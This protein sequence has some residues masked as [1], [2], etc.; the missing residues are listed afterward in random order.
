MAETV[1]CAACGA[2]IKG[3]R[4]RCLRCGEALD[5]SVAPAPSRGRLDFVVGHRGPFAIGGAAF[6]LLAMV[7]LVAP[8]VEERPTVSAASVMPS[9]SS[10]ASVSTTPG[11][12]QRAPVLLEPRTGL[13]IQRLAN[14]AYMR[15]DFAGAL[16]SYQETVELNP[17]D[18]T[19]LNNLGQALVRVG[20]PI[21]ALPYFERATAISPSEWTPR[22]NLAHAYGTM[23][24]WTHAITEYERAVELF[25]DDYVTH[26]N[27]ALAFHKAGREEPAVAEYRR[28]IALA[29]GEASFRLSLG[30]SYERLQRPIDAAA[31]YEEYLD[32]APDAA[33]ASQVKARIETLRKPVQG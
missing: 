28:A 2:K 20:R 25:P 18:S 17:N 29:P 4:T 15:G 9:L 1:I 32:L 22:F 6:G 30:I 8:R 31:A 33:D 14:A 16:E 26:Y 19:A 12:T 23:G 27:L 3:G 7:I 5:A 21:E 13:D 11:A 24:D 10:S